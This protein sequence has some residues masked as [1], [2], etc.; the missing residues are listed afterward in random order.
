MG[1]SRLRDGD[2]LGV[3]CRVTAHQGQGFGIA[4]P[5]GATGTARERSTGSAGA[6]DAL[7]GTFALDRAAGRAQGLGTPLGR[8][9]G[10]APPHPPAEEAS[11]ASELPALPPSGELP[12]GRGAASGGAGGGAR[13]SA[14]SR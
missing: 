13:A 2:T 8:G 7:G 9:V 11:S 12:A 4:F 1:C 10:T 3:P 14:A 6:G 5:R